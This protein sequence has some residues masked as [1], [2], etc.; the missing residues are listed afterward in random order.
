MV[1]TKDRARMAGM[2]RGLAAVAFALVILHAVTASGATRRPAAAPATRLENGFPSI[3]ALIGRFLGALTAKDQQALRRLR[4][5]QRE[6]IDIIMPG[7]IEP[8]RERKK[9]PEEKAEYF[10]EVLNTKSLYSEIAL[11]NGYGGRKYKVRDVSWA[12]GVKEFDGYTGYAQ[13]R[14][15]VQDEKGESHDIETGS[16]A[17]VGG[18]YK[19]VSYV[20]D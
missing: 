2:T 12:K 10:W 20:K 16:V 8:G 7:S 19:F 9:F 6:Y 13:L 4:V 1:G 14:L 11:L 5:N 15:T 17:K 18:R 3:D